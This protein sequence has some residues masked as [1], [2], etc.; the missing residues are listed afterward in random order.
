MDT[1]HVLTQLPMPSPDHVITPADV[2]A[3]KQRAYDMLD[4]IKAQ[5]DQQFAP[6]HRV[7]LLSLIATQLNKQLDD[8]D[9][10]WDNQ[11]LSIPYQASMILSINIH[12]VTSAMESDDQGGS[13]LVRWIKPKDFEVTI[14]Y[15]IVKQ[16]ILQVTPQTSS[17]E[18]DAIVNDN[19]F[20]Q[21]FQDSIGYLLLDEFIDPIEINEPIL[22]PLHA[23]LQNPISTTSLS[24]SQVDQILTTWYAQHTTDFDKPL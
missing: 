6:Y 22:V 21:A 20:K 5:Y 2:L 3:Y 15:N 11:V 16:T 4:N 13:E 8:I 19:A 18:S 10:A 14:D 17:A 1:N 12:H 9:V 23:I 7:Q 24:L